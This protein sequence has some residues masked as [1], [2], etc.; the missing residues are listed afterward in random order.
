ML[1]AMSNPALN[2]IQKCGGFQ[3]VADW[4]GVTVQTVYR[5]TWS[6]ERGGTNGCIPHRHMRQ[7]LVMAPKHGVVLKSSEFFEI[8]HA[9]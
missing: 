7:L 2:I 9:A 1:W 3:R 6:K 4:C 8:E 5:W